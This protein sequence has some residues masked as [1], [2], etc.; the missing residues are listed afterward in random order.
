MGG[1]GGGTTDTRGFVVVTQ[2]FHEEI[3]QLKRRVGADPLKKRQNKISITN[4]SNVSPS[5]S[6]S[7]FSIL[8]I[9]SNSF[10]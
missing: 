6:I 7:I 8:V 3:N 5:Y 9:L 10:I 4:H 1:G 2:R